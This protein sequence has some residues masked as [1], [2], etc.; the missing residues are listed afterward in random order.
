[1]KTNA[2]SSRCSLAVKLRPLLL[3]ED[4]FFLLL[5]RDVDIFLLLLLLECDLSLFEDALLDTLTFFVS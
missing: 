1:M 2:L 5:L 3:D 4:T